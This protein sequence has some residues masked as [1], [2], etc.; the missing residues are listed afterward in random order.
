MKTRKKKGKLRVD[1]LLA[2]IA[3]VF[4]TID[5]VSLFVITAMSSPA[6]AVYADD[7]M[8]EI[9]SDQAVALNMPI[10]TPP[11]A[12]I[13]VGNAPDVPEAQVM[14]TAEIGQAEEKVYFT[15]YPQDPIT[16]QTAAETAPASE[17]AAS[18]AAEQKETEK[19]AE[20]EEKVTDV[21]ENSEDKTAATETAPATSKEEA[22]SAEE[23]PKEP[24]P[25]E[26]ATEEKA[27]A[28][29]AD[30]EKTKEA[31][32]TKENSDQTAEVVE[33]Q[34]QEQEKPTVTIQEEL[35]IYTVESSDKTKDELKETI[36][37]E[38]AE[39]M[40]ISIDDID[41]DNSTVTFSDEKNI[42]NGGLSM[43]KVNVVLQSTSEEASVPV[44]GINTN[45]LVVETPSQAN[46]PLVLLEGEE[47]EIENGE[48]FDPMKNIAFIG[49]KNGILPVITI[50]DSAVDTTTDGTYPVTIHAVSTD[51]TS[52][53]ITYDVKVK[54][55]E[56]VLR[57]RAEEER[58]ARE[59]AEAEAKR[60]A[61]ANTY[62]SPYAVRGSGYNPYAGGWSNCTWGAWQAL[63]ERRGIALPA[64]GNAT[65]WYY[66]AA[67]MGYNV[68]SV[69]VA[70]SI[71][72]W[73]YDLT[74]YGHVAYVADVSADG[75]M[76][77][78]IEGGYLGHYNERWCMAHDAK[79]HGY[80][81]P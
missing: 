3:G 63:Y 29:E 64:M 23:E 2:L 25:A 19:P 21:T 14:E 41:M 81:Y 35:P 5:A 36:V 80:I 9:P 45:I 57:A 52:T 49:A 18:P 30:G 79:M 70:G 69:P 37:S 54:T 77:Y 53:D 8:I 43:Q 39:A 17:E 71:V 74:A 42:G 11:A 72:C 31:D 34:P 15:E 73:K 48:E 27:E 1:R 10:Y 40:D 12:M 60:Q 46:E 58:K 55:P 78:I 4:Y 24:A 50:D 76:I 7:S 56:E 16:E 47:C 59:A 44:E 68:G 22:A 28:K 62:S 61:A 20:T 32:T 13:A 38:A 26:S 6:A 51:G 33:E 66:A 65:N 75:S 67:S